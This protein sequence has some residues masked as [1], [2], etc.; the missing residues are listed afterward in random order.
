MSSA[1]GAA[2]GEA[3]RSREWRGLAVSIP[4]RGCGGVGGSGAGGGPGPLEAFARSVGT[5]GAART[6]PWG[7][8]REGTAAGRSRR[9][10]AQRGSPA[11]RFLG[12]ERAERRRGGAPER[13]GPGAWRLRGWRRRRQFGSPG[14]RR[15]LLPARS[16][17]PP[18][19]ARAPQLPAPLAPGLPAGGG[20]RAEAPAA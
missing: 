9:R 14:P 6:E 5:E 19:S 1:A 8:R 13:L 4:G 12:A 3:G 18:L 11:W 7:E 2:R 15:L 17:R 16:P 20:R 10:C